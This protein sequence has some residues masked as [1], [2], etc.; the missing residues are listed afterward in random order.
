MCHD[1]FRIDKFRLNLHLIIEILANICWRNE[2]II[3]R[4]LCWEITGL[5]ILNFVLPLIRIVYIFKSAILAR[6]CLNKSLYLKRKRKKYFNFLYS[7]R[8]D[9]HIYSIRGWDCKLCETKFHL[10]NCSPILSSHLALLHL[11]EMCGLGT[12]FS[13]VQKLNNHILLLT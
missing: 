6:H 9:L 10:Q 4:S 7:C 3:V 1:W 5:I 2:F 8:D 11:N 12:W 13:I